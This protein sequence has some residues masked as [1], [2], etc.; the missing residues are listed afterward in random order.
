MPQRTK[1]FCKLLSRASFS[2]SD[3]EVNIARSRQV[4]SLCFHATKRIS[5]SVVG[6]DHQATYF[7]KRPS[8]QFWRTLSCDT[9]AEI[10]ASVRPRRRS[11]E[12]RVGKECRV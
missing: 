12:R 2:K 5:V 11:E 6:I 4:I 3:S 9:C 10:V 8:V 7:L 1:V